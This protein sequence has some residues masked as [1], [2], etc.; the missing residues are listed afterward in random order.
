MAN[1][2]GKGLNLLFSPSH[3][4]YSEHQPF[5]HFSC[6]QVEFRFSTKSNPRSFLFIVLLARFILQPFK[7]V[8]CVFLN[9]PLAK[10]HAIGFS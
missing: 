5:S 2:L 9:I 6:L 4:R 3:A 7:C 10:E 8:Y 1:L